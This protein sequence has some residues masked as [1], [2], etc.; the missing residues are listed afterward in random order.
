LKGC[1]GPG[2]ADV[3]ARRVQVDPGQ[4]RGELGGGHLD[5]AG[6]GVGDTEGA[7]FESLG[8]GIPQVTVCK[9]KRQMEL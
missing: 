1:E 5:A 7:A 4:E 9:L 3:A 2:I 6:G 8:P